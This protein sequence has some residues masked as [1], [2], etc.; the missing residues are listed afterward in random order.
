M[1]PWAQP[2]SQP[3]RHLDSIGL[4]V[5]AGLMHDCDRQRDR[6]TDHDTPSV[7]IRR[8]YVVVRCGLITN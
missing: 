5:Y 7:T 8:I 4:A 3:K 6:Q 2:S 1:V